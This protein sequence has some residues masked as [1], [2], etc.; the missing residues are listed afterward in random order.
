MI[1][2]HSHILPGVDDG[3]KT[4][5]IAEQMCRMA[6]ADGTT[7]MVATPHS[8][9]EYAYDRVALQQKLD[10]L[11]RR[12]PEI[13]LSLGC[14]MH[15]SFDNIELAMREPARFAI[16]NTRYL[17]VEFSDYNV[18]PTIINVLLDLQSAGLVP[19]I[20]HPE[21]NPVLQRH[22]EYVQQF[23]ENGCL[24]QVTANSIT[25][26]WGSGPKRYS[27]S[28]LKKGLV[29]LIASDAHET[30]RRTPILS[31]AREMAAKIVGSERARSMVEDVPRAIVT[32]RKIIV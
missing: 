11:Q 17:L 4:W 15:L 26:F 25:G 16:G 12:V 23:A 3:A 29:H 30:K 32:N 28:L 21:R 22:P 10:E 19:I 1:D 24:I 20:T 13:E 18:P 8:N 27:E 2:V 7:H 31:A 5:E 9:D 14:D 6:L